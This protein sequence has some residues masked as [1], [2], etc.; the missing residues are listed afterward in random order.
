MIRESLSAVVAE[1]KYREAGSGIV[2]K[3]WWHTPC[4]WL[5]HCDDNLRGPAKICHYHG[6]TPYT[7]AAN[8]E[9]TDPYR[10]RR[11]DD[12]HVYIVNELSGKESV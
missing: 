12:L 3:N 2:F 5:P 6:L 10:V 1:R 8:S 9:V 7:M 4:S 11:G